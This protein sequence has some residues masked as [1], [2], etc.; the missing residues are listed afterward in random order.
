M[1]K[2]INKDW[3]NFV[4]ISSEFLAENTYKVGY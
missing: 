3:Q 2:K 1:K 4:D